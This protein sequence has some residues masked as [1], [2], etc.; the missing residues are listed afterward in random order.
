MQNNNFDD[1]KMINAI[2]LL[3][4]WFYLCNQYHPLYVFAYE[5]MD[6]HHSNPG[7]VHEQSDVVG[8]KSGE[9]TLTCKV[10]NDKF[11]EW[12]I[13][14]LQEF[15][16]KH[17]AEFSMVLGLDIRLIMLLTN[18]LPSVPL[19]RYFWNSCGFCNDSW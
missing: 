14:V 2:Y 8:I 5:I 13:P 4:I 18:I 16:R 3:W 12:N 9:P 17:P 15:Q 1:K 6:A 11:R 10:F 7:E 19:F